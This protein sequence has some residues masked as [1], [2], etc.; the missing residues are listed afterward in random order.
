MFRTF[1][2]VIGAFMLLGCREARAQDTT[3]Y[4]IFPRMAA[5]VNV[6]FDSATVFPELRRFPALRTRGRAVFD[7]WYSRSGQMDSI[8][9][10]DEASAGQVVS[11]SLLSFLRGQAKPFVASEKGWQIRLAVATGRRASLGLP[12][13]QT[14]RLRNAPYLE[15]ELQGIC[16][17]Q[18]VLCDTAG[19][20]VVVVTMVVSG[21]GS[22]E[23]VRVA[24]SDAGN[25]LRDEAMRIARGLRFEPAMIEGRPVD[26]L[27]NLPIT[28]ERQ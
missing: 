25:P 22:P 18:P 28:F 10:S 12:T 27:V 7:L 1:L 2:I 26:M 11:D 9:W 15:F 19:D 6:V 17:R 13:E 23:S 16:A 3:S 8:R 14:P 21:L 24:K 4:D 20:R 5:V